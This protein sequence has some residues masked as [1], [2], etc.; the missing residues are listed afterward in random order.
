MVAEAC[1]NE[2][3]KGP[4]VP[5]SEPTG[6]VPCISSAVG[7]V[8]AG[9]RVQEFEDQPRDPVDQSSMH[10]VVAKVVVASAPAEGSYTDSMVRVVRSPALDL[11]LEVA[12]SDT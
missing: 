10:G 7:A 4:L 3:R 2:R 5:S 8:Q 6:T 12:G 1:L 11:A 9:E